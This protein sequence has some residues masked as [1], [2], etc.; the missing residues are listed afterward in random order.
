MQPRISIITLGVADL[1][2][3]RTFYEAMGFAA[4]RASQPTIVFMQMAGQ[5]LALFP[6]GELAKDAGLADST[7]GFSGITLAH[8][9]GTKAE[10]DAIIAQAVRHGGREV[11]A[12]HDA[13][14]GGY[15]GYFADPDGHL[16]EVAWNPY[17]PLAADGTLTLPEGDAP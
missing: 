9:V 12:A 14:W 1:T 4:S 15:S 11:K 3:S 5:A 10:V 2:R 13:F 16:W 7:P 6:R 8:N 17:F